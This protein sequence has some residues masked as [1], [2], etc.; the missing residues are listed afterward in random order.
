MLIVFIY[1]I[2]GVSSSKRASIRTQQNSKRLAGVVLDSASADGEG[3]GAKASTEITDE[4]L[5]QAAA[6]MG[7]AGPDTTE[8]S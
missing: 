1:S 7:M 8:S 3:E 2:Q 5:A 4:M 6:S